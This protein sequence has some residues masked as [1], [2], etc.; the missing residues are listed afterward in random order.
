MKEAEKKNEGRKGKRKKR[1][2]GLDINTL[3]SDVCNAIPM[4]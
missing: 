3:Y 1:G 4:L 2:G